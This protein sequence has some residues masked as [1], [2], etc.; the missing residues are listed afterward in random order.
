M[1]GAAVGARQRVVLGDV[2][3]DERR[4]HDGKAARAQFANGG[5]NRLVGWRAAVG[6]SAVPPADE[7]RLR[8]GQ[9]GHAPGDR[10]RNLAVVLDTRLDLACARTKVVAEPAHDQRDRVER[11]QRR[12]HLV[13]GDGKVGG[14]EPRMGILGLGRGVDK[15]LRHRLR[16]IDELARAGDQHDTAHQPRRN[17]RDRG[18][19]RTR[20]AANDCRNRRAAT[21]RT[22]RKRR[23]DRP[24]HCRPQGAQRSTHR[25]SAA[26]RRGTRDR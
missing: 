3:E 26:R 10:R 2:H 4:Q 7:P 1:R 9:A 13:E 17:R 23:P 5:H 8:A 11:G 12:L 19:S 20:A 14:A 22:S 24:A 21:S 25:R 18:K 16:G 6:R 15:G